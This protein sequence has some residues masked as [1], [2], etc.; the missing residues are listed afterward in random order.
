MRGGDPIVAALDA[1]LVTGS[2]R[3]KE[4]DGTLGD[5]VDQCANH[6]LL[7][8]GYSALA[9][10]ECGESRTGGDFGFDDLQGGEHDDMTDRGELRDGTTG[11]RLAGL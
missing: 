5:Y 4:K 9:E 1:H 3:A 7:A 10:M 8:D 2:E 11:G 6:L